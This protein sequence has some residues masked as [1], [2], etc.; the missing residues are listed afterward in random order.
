MNIYYPGVY[1]MFLMWAQLCTYMYYVHLYRNVHTIPVCR[2][3]NIPKTANLIAD[4]FLTLHL[5]LCF[6]DNV[7][8]KYLNSDIYIY[9]NI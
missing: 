4:V 2:K 6:T 1:N 8:V 9:E 7:R 5:Q 3:Y